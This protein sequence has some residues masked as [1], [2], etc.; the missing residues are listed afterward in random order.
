MKEKGPPD[1]CGKMVHGRPRRRKAPQKAVVENGPSGG[2]AEWGTRRRDR[3]AGAKSGSHQVGHGG[4]REVDQHVSTHVCPED[5]VRGG[6]YHKE[7]SEAEAVRPPRHQLHPILAERP[8]IRRLSAAPHPTRLVTQAS[9]RVEVRSLDPTVQPTHLFPISFCFL[10]SF[11]KVRGASL[12][13]PYSFPSPCFLQ[14]ILKNKSYL[15]TLDQT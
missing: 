12:R 6:P 5:D 13:I 4:V 2:H 10:S 7:Q 1:D 3:I 14:P 8:Q 9:H 11:G 15:T